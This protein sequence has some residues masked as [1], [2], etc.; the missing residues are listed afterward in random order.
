MRRTLRFLWTWCRSN[1][2]KPVHEQHQGLAAQLR[3]HYSYF[4]IRS[5]YGMLEAVY[6]RALE[7]WRRWLGRRS[8][9]G[10]LSYA[11]FE[12]FLNRYPLPMP[13]IVH[14]I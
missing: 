12:A 8:T 11:K 13:R 2:H 4:G 9:T 10:H 5:N 6:E 7:T 14:A 3:G 1:K